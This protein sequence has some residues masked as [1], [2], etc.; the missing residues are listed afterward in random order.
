[1]K[2]NHVAFCTQQHKAVSLRD[3][4]YRMNNGIPLNVP[5]RQMFDSGDADKESEVDDNFFDENADPLE[6]IQFKRDKAEQ[7]FHEHKAK[8]DDFYKQ[9]KEKAEKAAQALAEF[10]KMKLKGGIKDE[11]QTNEETQN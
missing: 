6:L 3:L 1:M 10:E 11:A 8:N 5:V 4:W 2:K 9:F 7:L